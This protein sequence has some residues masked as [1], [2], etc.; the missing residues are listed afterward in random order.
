MK[1]FINYSYLLFGGILL[2]L[3]LWNPTVSIALWF[4][5]VFLIR[6]TRSMKALPGLLLLCIVSYV[7]ILIC[8]WQSMIP[9]PP[10]PFYFDMIIALQFLPVPFIPYLADRLVSPRLKVV[11]A[12]LVFPLASIT[13]EMINYYALGIPGGVFLEGFYGSLPFQQ[14]LPVTGQWGLLFLYAWAGP[15]INYWWE[16]Y[17]NLKGFKDIPAL[18]AGLLI[19]VLL[20]GGAWTSFFPPSAPATRIAAITSTLDTSML[21]DVMPFVAARKRPPQT[22]IDAIGRRMVMTDNELHEATR[23]A[24]MA[25]ANIVMWN[26]LAVVVDYDREEKFIERYR[27][28]ARDTGIYLVICMAVVDPD[29]SMPGENLLCIIDPSGA[30]IA[31][32]RKRHLIPG[33]ETPLFKETNDPVPVVH[34]PY[35][36]VAAVICYDGLFHD[37][38][39]RVS[40]GVDIMLNPSLDWKGISPVN[41]WRFT[42]RA[43]E[44]GFS[45]V[46]CTG[47]GFSA[48]VDYQG[49]LLSSMDYFTSTARIMYADVPSR[50]IS[51]IYSRIGDLFGWIGVAVFFVLAGL[52]IFHK[53]NKSS[54]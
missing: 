15:I 50:G 9:F 34:T 25:G 41:T 47:H 52:A 37:F 10:Y 13:V 40:T 2:M 39:R 46:R 14:L 53:S 28:L 21:K 7:A 6:F 19:T 5:P 17:F 23:K 29:L 11:P 54:T 48:A 43:A 45:F 16:H 35:G 30:V 42:F 4:A 32:Y 36:T 3:S 51:T 24:A 31:R 20:L 27:L 26:E 44:N 18:Y 22:I 12:T 38:M 1:K 49:R 33:L 8:L